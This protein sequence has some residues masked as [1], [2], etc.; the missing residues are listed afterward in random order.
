MRRKPA[1]DLVLFAILMVLLFLPMLQG[2]F[3]L[4]P[5][6]P[7]HG[8]TLNAE[9]PHLDMASYRSG[10]FAK[11]EEAYLAE[12]FGFRESV[13][14]LY[15]QY[16]WSCYK[17]TY[18]H[19]VTAGKHG[20]L[21]YPQSVS[22]YYGTELLQWQ[23]SVEAARHN[24]D[25]EVKYMDWTRAILKENGV[26]LLVFMAPE[27]GALYPEFLP[28]G[29]HDTTTFNA[30]EYFEEK[31]N[32]AGFP[33]IE[34]T[35]W[36]QQMKDTVD[37]PLIP[38]TG[39]H[40]VFPAVFAADSLFHYMGAL[41]G[42]ALPQIKVGEL[43]E[44]A[45]H[46]L[47]N[48]LEQLLNLSLP[49]NHRYGF[50]PRAEVR[51]E[52][53]PTTVKPRVLFIGNSYM[54]NIAYFVPLDEVFDKVEFWY[55]FST[56]Y[57]GDSLKE[58]TPVVDL[59][60]LEKLL[61]FDYIVWFNTGNQMNKG[62]MGFSKTALLTLCASDS[63]VQ[64]YTQHIAD[65]LTY[66]CR[67]AI[68]RVS[69]DSLRHQE[70]RAILYNHPELIPELSG[71]ELPALRNKEIPYVGILKEIRSDSLW[72]AALEAQSF[73]RTATLNQMLHAEADRIREGKPLYKDNEAE[74]LFGK[75]CMN[76]AEQLVLRMPNNE[77]QMQAIRQH[78]EQQGKT[79]E[80]TM[81]DDAVW[82]I[83]RKYGLDRCRLA[84][85][86]DAEIPLP[87]DFQSN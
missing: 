77:K 70:A 86:P 18:A 26:E 4:I 53:D 37:Y 41:K 39:A 36:F 10:T 1:Y 12:H 35:R 15:N 56:A 60:I 67:D 2:R 11:Q 78:M 85:D 58:T 50:C 66:P 31:F 63:L 38:Q 17:K 19:D 75:R 28:D 43:H 81:R 69:T 46:G 52:S 14:R 59:N 49:I 9:K 62:T 47:D 57:S 54:W 45:K 71:D 42:V 44:S 3:Q 40:W 20:W 34:M 27:K 5:L 80:Q 32:E 83:Q 76:E 16:L 73:V 24:F 33:C 7:L 51:I 30:R 82:L 64:A 25:L 72:M 29:E 23:P 79:L 21:Y 87:P 48:D 22:D 74:I 55:Y 65:T 13:I 68:N 8:V 61:E 84:D 6:K